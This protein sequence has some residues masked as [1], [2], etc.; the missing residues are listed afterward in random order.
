MTRHLHINDIAD[1]YHWLNL[2]I[3]A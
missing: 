2:N 1:K 3:S